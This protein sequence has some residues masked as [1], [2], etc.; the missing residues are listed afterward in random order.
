M[1]RGDVNQTILFVFKVHFLQ[2]CIF[3]TSWNVFSNHSFCT[4]IHAYA[5]G[6]FF[7]L[8]VFPQKVAPTD[9][10]EQYI[11]YCE[12]VIIPANILNYGMFQHSFYLI[13]KE[14]PLLYNE[15]YLLVHL[16]NTD[17]HKEG[18]DSDCY[19]LMDISYT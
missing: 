19:L 10:S 12:E 1:G 18:D 7:R 11:E 2:T 5:T 15:L 17:T 9:K 13:W 16:H 3:Y 8:V 6:D 14:P 4:K